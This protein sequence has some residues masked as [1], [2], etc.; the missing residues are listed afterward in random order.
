M[1]FIEAMSLHM[2]VSNVNISMILSAR[3]MRSRHVNWSRFCLCG[4]IGVRLTS[5]KGP[6]NLCRWTNKLLPIPGGTVTKTL[7]K[8]NCLHH[9][10]ICQLQNFCLI[11]LFQSQ[12]DS[13]SNLIKS[14]SQLA[15]NQVSVCPQPTSALPLCVVL[16]CSVKQMLWFT[17]DILHFIR[18]WNSHLVISFTYFS[19][20]WTCVVCKFWSHFNFYLQDML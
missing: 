11:W 20:D 5:G 8:E 1:F 6:P 7:M 18:E 16:L 13:I 4:S 9:L 15:P 12:S 17:P 3:F 10:G 2:E 19:M 14:G